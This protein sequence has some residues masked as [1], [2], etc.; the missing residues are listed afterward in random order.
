MEEFASPT[1]WVDVGWGVIGVGARSY[2]FM[3]ELDEPYFVGG[4]GRG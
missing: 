4:G 1:F 3:E 2:E